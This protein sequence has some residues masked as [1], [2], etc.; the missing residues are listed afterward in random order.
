MDLSS[1]MVLFA[2]V[3]EA[4]SFSAAARSL[5]HSPSGISRQIAHLEDSLGLRLLT[6]TS[7]GI[8]TTDEGQQ[9]FERCRIVAAEVSEAEALLDYLTDRPSGRLNV[10]ST[11]AFGNVQLLPVLPRFLRDNP[12]VSLSLSLTD[13]AFDFHSGEI[14]VAVQFSEQI[15]AETAISRKLA[16]NRRVLVAAPEY[17]RERGTPKTHADLVDHACLTL[18]TVEHWNDWIPEAPPSRP[19]P[20]EA[21]TADAVYRAALAGLGIARLSTYLVNADITAGRLVRVLPAYEQQDS[22][23]VAL[24]RER[25]NLSPKIRAFLDFLVETY[26]PVPPWEREDAAEETPIAV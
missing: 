4:G 26:N 3:V 20:F 9:F 12:D 13:D 22:N 2:R 18:S 10:V 5:H 23:I 8:A 24:Y 17:L 7:H 25:R 1:Q 19:A 11:V 16:V 21:N 15:S 6:R 14:D